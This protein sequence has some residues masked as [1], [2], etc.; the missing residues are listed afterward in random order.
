MSGIEKFD[1]NLPEQLLNNFFQKIE[2]DFEKY[3]SVFYGIS[4]V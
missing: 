1:D 3:L 2:N 4:E